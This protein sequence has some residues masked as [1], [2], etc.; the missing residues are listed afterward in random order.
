[1]Y[2]VIH[3]FVFIYFLVSVSREVHLVHHLTAHPD[4]RLGPHQNAP[5]ATWLKNRLLLLPLPLHHHHLLLPH[6]LCH[7][8]PGS[9]RR[10]NP[11]G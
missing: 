8:L 4:P 6:L 2:V 10:R 9:V 1:M 3:V 11:P 7:H 5:G